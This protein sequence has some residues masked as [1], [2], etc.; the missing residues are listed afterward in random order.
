MINWT[1]S[2][3]L[4]LLKFLALLPNSGGSITNCKLNPNLK[5]SCLPLQFVAIFNPNPSRLLDGL[6]R[7]SFHW[8]F[9]I[10]A[11]GE[12]GGRGAFFF[13]YF[14]YFC[15]IDITRYSGSSFMQLCSVL[16]LKVIFKKKHFVIH[17]TSIITVYSMLKGTVPRKS[18]WDY[19]LGC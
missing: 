3:A 5:V 7:M 1:T 16:T 18:V 9:T 2:Q 19:D 11:I 8:K 17:I 6:Y 10:N 12:G 15:A 14:F 13:I 4:L